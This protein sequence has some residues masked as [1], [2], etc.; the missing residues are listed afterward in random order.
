[1]L[2]IGQTS[3]NKTQNLN[4]SMPHNIKYVYP[5]EEILTLSNY[6]ISVDNFVQV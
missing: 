6:S 1:M 4:I 3:T 5:I 2:I